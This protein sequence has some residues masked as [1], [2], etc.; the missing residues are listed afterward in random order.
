MYQGD[1][2]R[3]RYGIRPGFTIHPLFYLLWLVDLSLE[4]VRLRS[5]RWD[6]RDRGNGWEVHYVHTIEQRKQVFVASACY[7]GAF[8]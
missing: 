6:G 8:T 2:W 7:R 5:Y 4:R 1:L 3:N